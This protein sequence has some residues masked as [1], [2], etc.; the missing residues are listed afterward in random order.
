LAN[1]PL[2]TGRIAQLSALF[3]SG[4]LGLD[5]LGRAFRATGV[6]FFCKPKSPIDPLETPNANRMLGLMELLSDDLGRS[7]RAQLRLVPRANQY[8]PKKLCFRAKN[9]PKITQ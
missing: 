1:L 2:K 7:V 8:P 6:K 3:A 4:T 5:L 9:D